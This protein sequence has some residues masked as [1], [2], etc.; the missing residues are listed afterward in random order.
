M[1]AALLVSVEGQPLGHYTDVWVGPLSAA[2]LGDFLSY[3]SLVS[4]R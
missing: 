2:T 3:R 4:I 1:L